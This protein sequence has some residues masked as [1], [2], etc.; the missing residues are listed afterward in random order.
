MKVFRPVKTAIIGCGM[1]SDIY[2]KN[3][4]ERFNVLEVVG[5]SDLIAER[6]QAK[7]QKYGIR[8][9]TN[10]EILSDPEIE[11]IINLTFTVAH[12]EVTKAA[13]LAGKHV[14]SEKMMAVRFEEA[15]EL[16][17]L[18]K[19]KGLSLTVAPDTFL[20]ARLQTARQIVDSGLIGRPITA[21]ISLSRCYRHSEFKEESEKRFAFCPGGG[22]LN[23]VGCYYLA[24]LIN[25]VGPV[26]KVTGFYD[27]YEP[28]RPWRNPKNPCYGEDMVYEDAPNMYAGALLFESGVMCGVTITSE[29]WG[30]GS[31]FMLHGT[32]GSLYL[33][34]PN[35]FGGPLKVEL[36]GSKESFEFGLTHAYADN[37]R[38][39]G[40]ADAAY[41]IRNGRTARCNAEFALHTFETACGVIFSCDT[42][43]IYDMTTRCER[44]E[45]FAPG[46]TE[47]PELVMD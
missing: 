47:Y 27:T 3:C 22:I 31:R 38:G 23:D 12:Y 41:A 16:V 37:S 34:D 42:G 1:I 10:E 6:A 36:K 28:R 33:D 7:A 35:E 43:K 13:L 4:V 17:A 30:G 32:Q 11:L 15:Q 5:C 20:G 24:G 19:E 14:H 26:S 44:P 45:P 25:L 8:A 29:T 39:L 9:M 40:A 18:A 46:H 21:E 2:L